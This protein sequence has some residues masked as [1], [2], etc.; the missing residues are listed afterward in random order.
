MKKGL[1]SGL[2]LV[3]ILA[4]ALLIAFLTM[5]QMG[6]SSFGIASDKAQYENPVEQAQ[7]VVDAINNR[8]QQ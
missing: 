3:I 5:K 8:T 6:S 7:D 1:S 2:V 4:A